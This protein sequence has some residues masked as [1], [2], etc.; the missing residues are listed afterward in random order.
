MSANENESAEREI[1]EFF[2]NRI[3]NS[4]MRLTGNLQVLCLLRDN[5]L[6]QENGWFPIGPV[7]AYGVFD[8]L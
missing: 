4:Q 8:F 5:Q 3:R 6:Q 7:E 1:S 2:I